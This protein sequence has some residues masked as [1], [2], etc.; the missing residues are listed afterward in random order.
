[1]N[2][3]KH[4][5]DFIYN[6]RRFKKQCR[7]GFLVNISRKSTFEGMNQIH[8]YSKFNGHLGFGSYIGQDCD[9]CAHIGKYCS[10]S[11]K[12]RT[13]AGT[14]PYTYPY[15]ATAPCFYATNPH[16]SQNGSTFATEDTISQYRTADSEGKYH[17]IIGNDCWIGDSVLLIGGIKI[18]DGAVVLAGAVVTKDVPPFAIVGG[19][20]AKIL[21]YRYDMKTISG[22]VESEWWNKD[23]KWFE[24]NWRLMSDVNSFVENINK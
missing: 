12:V 17:V 19:V 23:P 22:L 14:H 6:K 21:K 1:M 16:K 9:I 2:P 24:N 8:P 3:I 5:L 15:V 4:L 13:I 20:P 10:I 11:N 7:F 18:G